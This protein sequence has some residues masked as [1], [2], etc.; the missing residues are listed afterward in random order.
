MRGLL[1]DEM[2]P[3]EAAALLREMGH[4]VGHVAEV[5]LQATEDSL[6]AAVARAEQ[7]GVVTENVQDF[8]AE[9]DM[10]LVFVLKRHLPSGGAQAVALARMLHRWLLDNPDPYLGAHWPRL[11]G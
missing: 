11:E 7:R 3:T 9:Q 6:V 2:F 5:G 4:D 1:L 10:V 8:A